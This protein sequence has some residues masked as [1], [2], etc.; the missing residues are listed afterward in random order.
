MMQL[1]LFKRKKYEAR[2]RLNHEATW[3]RKDLE[4]KA[5]TDTE[6]IG[7]FK[8]LFQDA[9]AFEVLR[10]DPYFNKKLNDTRYQNIVIY[11]N[12]A[13]YQMRQNKI[14]AALNLDFLRG[15]K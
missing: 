9:R 11:E 5:F 13:A 12:E 7:Y 4:Y 14:A 6:A 8:D 10:L 3:T 2:I 1:E 15:C